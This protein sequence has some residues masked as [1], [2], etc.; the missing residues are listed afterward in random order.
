MNKVRLVRLEEKLRPQVGCRRV[1]PI[2]GWITI[3]GGKGATG[4]LC[5]PPNHTADQWA[6][7]KRIE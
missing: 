7:A 6:A 1:D 2:T 3:G 4:V 5:V